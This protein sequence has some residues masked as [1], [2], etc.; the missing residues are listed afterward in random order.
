[1]RH[2]GSILTL[3]I[4]IVIL[5]AIVMIAILSLGAYITYNMFFKPIPESELYGTY[6]VTYDSVGTDKLT[7][8]PDGEYTQEVNVVDVNG[9]HKT[10]K[11]TN[12]W[13]YISKSRTLRLTKALVI[14]DGF[15]RLRKDYDIP[16]LDCASSSVTRDLRGQ[17]EISAHSEDIYYIKEN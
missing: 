13:E 9:I 8:K 12:H 4:L 16:F 5:A 10:V 1:M 3:L 14:D 11:N 2:K 6:V 15:G 7:I 17:I